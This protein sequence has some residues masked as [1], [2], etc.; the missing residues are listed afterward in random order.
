MWIVQEIGLASR[1]MILLDRAS[2]SWEHLH[3]AR[4]IHSSPYIEDYPLWEPVAN[5]VRFN[6][7]R[8][9]Q[10][11]QAF[12][13]GFDTIC[14]VQA[15]QAFNLDIHRCT[16]YRN[17]LKNLLRVVKCRNA[18][19]Q[20]TRFTGSLDLLAI[21]K[22]VN[23]KLTIRNLLFGVYADVISFFQASRVRRGKSALVDLI[24]FNH[25]RPRSFNEPQE[26]DV[27]AKAV[28]QVEHSH[29]GQPRA[30]VFGIKVGIVKELIR[31]LDSKVQ[32]RPWI[33]TPH[34]S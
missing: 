34:T 31:S 25:V 1:I 7:I 28:S 6:T 4:M 5:N 11:S 13:L 23:F 16:P 17:V 30:E 15:S 32:R 3:N 33:R 20:E 29:L 2:A 8:T 12:K 18:V 21:I 27:G 19:I 26:L 10:A 14:T 9:V 22:T 24:R